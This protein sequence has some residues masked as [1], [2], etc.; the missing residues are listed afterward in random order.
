MAAINGVAAGAGA[1]IALC[2]DVVVATEAASFIQAFSKIGL[3]P[4]AK[5]YHK[6]RTNFLQFYKQLHFFGRARINVYKFFPNE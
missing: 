6:R 2:C 1:N 5:V 4:D 3:I